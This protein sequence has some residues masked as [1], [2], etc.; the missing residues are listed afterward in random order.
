[1]IVALSDTFKPPVLIFTTGI[2]NVEP[3]ITVLVAGLEPDPAPMI[4]RRLLTVISSLYVPALT[5]IV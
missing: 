5:V 3:W 2:F 1:M 4:V